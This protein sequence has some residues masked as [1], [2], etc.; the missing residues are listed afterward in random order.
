MITESYIFPE[1]TTRVVGANLCVVGSELA[2]LETGKIIFIETNFSEVGKS[3]EKSLQSLREFMR[4]S[5]SNSA[6]WASRTAVTE[7]WRI[8]HKEEWDG[9]KSCPVSL[10]TYETALRFVNALPF[11]LKI[12]PY[13]YPDSKGRICFDWENSKGE[14]LTVVIRENRLIFA[15]TYVNGDQRHGS[16]KFSDSIPLDVLTNLSKIIDEQ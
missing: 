4:S 9:P 15:A 1:S 13:V 16:A 6:V 3:L 2:Q 7:A 5:A 11:A 12:A 14:I 10:G 8:A